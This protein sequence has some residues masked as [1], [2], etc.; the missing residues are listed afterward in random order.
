MIN[1]GQDEY[2][3]AFAELY[4]LHSPGLPGDAAFYVEEA[5]KGS[6]VLELGC[7]TGRIALAMAGAGVPVTGL[8]LAKTML[9]IARGKLD[10]APEDVRE[11]VTLVRADMRRFELEKRFDLAIFPYRTFMHLLEPADQKAALACARKHLAPGG[12][13]ALDI[14]DVRPEVLVES[15]AGSVLRKTADLVV[16]GRW[17]RV[18]VSACERV[19]RESQRI[20]EDLAFEELDERGA[21]RAKT[22][23]RRS[24]RYTHRYEMQ[25]LLELSG[26]EVEALHGDFARGPFVPG[27]EQVWLA[28]RAGG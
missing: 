7:G 5:K 25:W 11:R 19:D 12:R 28:R 2:E 13:L 14:A 6:S 8:D 10:A 9:A 4:D 27:G 18:V 22:W 1:A 21:V 15:Q 20:D 24:L 26:F 17:T 16:P 3:G 23:Q